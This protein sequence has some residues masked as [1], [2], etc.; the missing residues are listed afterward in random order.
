MG[1]FYLDSKD[2]NK[3][4]ISTSEK[5]DLIAEYAEEA[6]EIAKAAAND[7]FPNFLWEVQM[8][9]FTADDYR[10]RGTCEDEKVREVYRLKRKYSDYWEYLDAMQIYN[11]YAEY[12]ESAYG[13]FEMMRNAAQEGYSTV[14][15]PKLP[16]LTNKKKN[17]DF[18]W[19]GFL[20]SRIDD[21]AILDT[22]AIDAMVQVLPV[23]ELD[24]SWDAYIPEQEK[25][26]Q[27]QVI[28][29]KSRSDR[30]RTM[31]AMSSA[32]KPDGMDAIIN[33]LNQANTGSID[34]RVQ[35][36]V[37]SVSDI[38][39]DIHEFDLV[40]PDIVEYNLSPHNGIVYGGYLADQKQ[41]EQL[42][43]LEALVSA[44]FDFLDSDASK[45]IKKENIRA[46]TRRYGTMK[47]PA[48]MTPAER[49]RYIKEMA[50]RR[51]SQHERL[52]GDKRM[53]QA[54][55][56]NR[57]QFERMDSTGFRISDVLPTDDD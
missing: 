41:K 45:G 28:I 30:V 5:K 50:K 53:S 40:P 7:V 36:E 42:K 43:I 2:L 52:M 31:F 8:N 26:I 48:D 10:L 9:E 22:D 21:E 1:V 25:R 4:S 51:R 6:L 34:A 55:L 56:L 35:S 47:N 44:G 14:Y 29:S 24:E 12:I 33:F 57:V 17:R 16:K 37:W 46:I 39:D 32:S 15:I 23:A 38:I 54:L 3:Y 20:P 18:L 49:K 11:A 13:S 27:E 19:T